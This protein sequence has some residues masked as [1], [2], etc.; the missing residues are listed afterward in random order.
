[1]HADSQP[2]YGIA[3]SCLLLFLRQGGETSAGGYTPL[4]DVG[5]RPDE[6][7]RQWKAKFLL[8]QTGRGRR[9]R[10]G[11]LWASMLCITHLKLPYTVIKMI[12]N[13][14]LLLNVFLFLSSF[15]HWSI[16]RQEESV[17]SFENNARFEGRSCLPLYDAVAW[18]TLQNQCWY[19]LKVLAVE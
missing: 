8:T 6:K 1:M 3:G 16:K 9:C 4:G 13:I 11:E 2:A 5:N 12:A 15:G 19:A 18:T 14:N 17:L 7:S 10:S